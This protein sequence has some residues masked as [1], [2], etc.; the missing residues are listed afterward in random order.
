[1]REWLKA[2]RAE[3]KLSQE[4]VARQSGIAQSYYGMIEVGS[5]GLPVPTAKK[6]AGVLGFDWK[7]FYEDP[8]DGKENPA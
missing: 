3:K 1:M 5:R 4:E 2:L 8:E 7:R 6:I